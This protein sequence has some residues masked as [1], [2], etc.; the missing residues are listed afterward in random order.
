MKVLLSTGLKGGV[1]KS[2]IA[3][4]IAY[5]LAKEANVGMVDCDIDSSNL[6]SIIGVKHKLEVD[7]KT[8]NFIPYVWNNGSTKPILVVSTAM[9]SDE[10][11]TFFKLG[12]EIE[13]MT[14]DIVKNTNW[15]NTDYLVIDM[16]ASS[17]NILKTVLNTVS[18]DNLLGMVLVA[19]PNAHEDCLRVV[20][21]AIRLGIPI[22]GIIE[23][24][25]GAVSKD[26]KRVI[27]EGTDEPFY[28]FGEGG[29]NKAIA[30]KFGVRYIGSVPMVGKLDSPI[31]PEVVNKPILDII[32]IIRG[33]YFENGKVGG[34][35]E[36]EVGNEIKEKKEKSESAPKEEMAETS[37]TLEVTDVKN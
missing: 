36:T 26:G 37:K 32:S 9:F 14:K 34:M 4:N 11:A 22:I 15:G 12:R 19:Q 29:E 33:D 13:Q 24:M 30:D 6:P 18:K 35:L 3:V 27:F 25:L 20:Q 21:L 8:H 28:P 31:L 5:H 16:P 23:N 10:V 1:G 17:S 7:R 2:L